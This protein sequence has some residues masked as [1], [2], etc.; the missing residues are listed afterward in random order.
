MWT[1]TSPERRVANE[2]AAAGGSAG[3]LKRRLGGGLGIRPRGEGDRTPVWR[4]ADARPVDGRRQF[5][6]QGGA[7]RRRDRLQAGGV[8]KPAERRPGRDGT[9]PLHGPDRR[10][11]PAPDR[12]K[13]VQEK[14]EK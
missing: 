8:R 13:D 4:A 2:G 1:C 10:K 14:L 3:N 12:K 5:L 11:R 9:G 6:R 7:A